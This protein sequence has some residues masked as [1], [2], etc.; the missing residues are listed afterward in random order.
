M[1]FGDGHTLYRGNGVIPGPTK[2]KGM[3]LRMGEGRNSV[4]GYLL[5]GEESEEDSSRKGAKHAKKEGDGDYD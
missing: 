2:M 4:I 3:G 1:L 5:L